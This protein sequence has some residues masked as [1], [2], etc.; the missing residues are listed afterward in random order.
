MLLFVCVCV[1]V[2]IHYEQGAGSCQ[3]LGAA[4]TNEADE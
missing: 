3:G 2:Y 1:C 4:G